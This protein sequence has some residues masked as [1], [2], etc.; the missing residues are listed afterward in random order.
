MTGI[1]RIDKTP[2]E[3]ALIIDYKYSSPEWIAKLVKGHDAGTHIQGGIY[4][5]TVQNSGREVAGMHFAGIRGQVAWAGWEDAPALREVMEKS[6]QVVLTAVAR[7]R[8]GVI[9]PNPADQE[10]CQYCDFRDACRV[11]SMAKA[12]VSGEGGG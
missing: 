4:I 10:L 3:K 2:D 7:I 1:D 5:L 9:A 12:A 6:R 11:E 8:G